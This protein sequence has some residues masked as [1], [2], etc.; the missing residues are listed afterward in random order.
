MNLESRFG[1]RWRKQGALWQ[2]ACAFAPR[3]SG[4]VEHKKTAPQRGFFTQTDALIVVLQLAFNHP[5]L[6]AGAKTGF[7]VVRI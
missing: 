3:F 1:L 5:H 6:V 2:K 7:V 4:V